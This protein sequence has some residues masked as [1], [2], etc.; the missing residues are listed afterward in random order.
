MKI[1]IKLFISFLSLIGLFVIAIITN[2]VLQGKSNQMQNDISSDKEE[3]IFA[4][5]LYSHVLAAD[6]AGAWY[7]LSPNDANKKL[8][9]NN[10][11][12][13]LKATQSGLNQLKRNFNH[14]RQQQKD[15][16]QFET[17]WGK[18]QNGNNNA[19]QLFIQGA[20]KK[21]QLLYTE[22]P[23]EPTIRPLMNYQNNVQ[24]QIADQKQQFESTKSTIFW[25]NV[26]ITLFVILLGLGMALII[27]RKITKSIIL[28]SRELKE[29]AEG[30][31]DLTRKL[32]I[33]SHDEV[34]ELADNFNQMIAN[35][36]KVISQVG[37]DTGQVAA[38]SEELTASAEQTSKA[39]E[40][41]AVTIQEIAEGTT[42]QVHQAEEAS[43]VVHE[44][45]IGIQ[46]IA[47][48][49]QNVSETAMEAAE[50]A[51]EGG[52][53]I[54][55]TVQKM[56]SINNTVNNLSTVVNGLEKNSN[57]IG[58]ITGVI[59]EI[60]EQTNL[61]ALNAAIEAAR[62]GEHGKGFAVVADEVRKLA[63]ESSHST[64]K[65]AELIN[66][67][68]SENKKVVQSMDFAIKEVAGGI[69]IATTAG[70]DFNL[71]QA[72]INKVTEQIQEVAAAVQE[73]SAGAE[74]T[75]HSMELIEKVAGTSAA[76]TQ[77]VS[78]ATEEQLASMEEISSA[79]GALSKMMEELQI[80][81]GKFKY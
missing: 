75:V 12:N 21:A 67:I 43:H 64:Q 3:L 19:F 77:E 54:Q 6:D 34:G 59:T 29:I 76:D 2:S 81:I 60:A 28:V 14:D 65:I 68:Q 71:I 79:A 70:K 69:E 31:G 9:F 17:N 42:Q 35:L 33:R 25:L 27:P 46:Q 55:T 18:Y 47:S 11:Q 57:E 13:E 45:S 8:Y 10:Y 66:T 44:I 73:M 62:A 5:T 74:D 32:S 41:V 38:S 58:K 56:N 30:E 52:K 15:L 51:S 78:A 37:L 40:Q 63:E 20:T 7:L 22:V 49:A 16:D 24:K 53:T 36:R 26:F 80:L 4:Q 50:K 72:S 1:Q 39:A 23:F 48:N 61:L